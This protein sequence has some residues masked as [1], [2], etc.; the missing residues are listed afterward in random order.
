MRY[1]FSFKVATFPF[2]FLD[3][4]IY[5]LSNSNL[6][7]LYKYYTIIDVNNV[8]IRFSVITCYLIYRHELGSAYFDFTEL[9][10]GIYTHRCCYYTY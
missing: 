9:L 2:C 1:T 7:M 6:S 3:C 5:D 10:S 8:G 4:N